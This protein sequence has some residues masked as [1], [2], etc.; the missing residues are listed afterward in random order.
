MNNQGKS[1]K[2]DR[3]RRFV[4]KIPVYQQANS[5]PEPVYDEEQP[6]Q[7]KVV[8]NYCEHCCMK[9]VK[10]SAATQTSEPFI[11]LAEYISLSK[12]TREYSTPTKLPS[13]SDQDFKLNQH[14]AEN[15]S[16]ASTTADSIDITDF[17]T[18]Y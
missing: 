10:I 1:L 3:S 2:F 13:S 9:T 8:N 6:K 11:A 14:S 18:T 5:K 4:T 15:I 16:I 17:K 12:K 7:H